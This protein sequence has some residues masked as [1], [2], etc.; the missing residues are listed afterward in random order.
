MTFFPLICTTTSVHFSQFPFHLY[1][2]QFDYQPLLVLISLVTRCHFPPC[3]PPSLSPSFIPLSLR[4]LSLSPCSTSPLPLLLTLLFFFPNPLSVEPLKHS[5][6][7]GPKVHFHLC[8]RLQW[9]ISWGTALTLGEQCYY[10][11]EPKGVLRYHLHLNC[12]GLRW[13]WST[14]VTRLFE[15]IPWLDY[16]VL[17]PV[18]TYVCVLQSVEVEQKCCLCLQNHFFRLPESSNVKSALSHQRDQSSLSL[19][20]YLSQ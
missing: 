11:N 10:G 15:E 12:C 2:H 13:R 18:S 9:T 3:F 4:W 19:A 1:F 14:T 17:R 16:E 7:E 6:W 20:G 8:S 5:H